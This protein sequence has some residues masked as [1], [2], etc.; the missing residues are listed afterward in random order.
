MAA[1]KVAGKDYDDIP[2]T[3]VFDADR[4]RQGY[5]EARRVLKPG[6]RFFFSDWDRIEDNEF[7][8][9]VTQA[10]CEIFPNDPPLFMARTPHGYHDVAK[11]RQHVAAAGFA[12][13]SVQTIAARSKAPSPREVAIA[14][15]RGTPLQGEIEARDASGL[16]AATR[17]AA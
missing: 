2:G 17:K 13:V 9:V 1:K 10:L 8:D 6:G 14:Y 15:C 16:E 11:I 5:R 7:P 4:S 12:D 3:Y